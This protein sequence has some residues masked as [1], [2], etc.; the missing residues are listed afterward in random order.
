MLYQTIKVDIIH[1]IS[2]YDNYHNN[3]DIDDEE[4]TNNYVN[5]NLLQSISTYIV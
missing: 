5:T 1:D 3:G 4:K 2:F